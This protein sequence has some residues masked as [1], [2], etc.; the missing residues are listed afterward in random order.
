MQ[1]TQPQATY[2]LMVITATVIKKLTAQNPLNFGVVGFQSRHMH[3]SYS[4]N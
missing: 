1:N 3:R 4:A 2:I